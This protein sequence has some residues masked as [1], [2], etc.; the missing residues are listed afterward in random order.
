MIEEENIASISLHYYMQEEGVH[1]MDAF[2]HNKCERQLLN[3]INYLS[4]QYGI[5]VKVDIEAKEEGGIKDKI[6]VIAESA[7]FLLLAEKVL[8]MVFNL[9]RAYL[10]NTKTRFEIAEMIKNSSFTEEEVNAL[11]EQDE[12]LIKF[13]SSYFKNLS[14]DDTVTRV[15]T[16]L[17]KNGEVGDSITYTVT[18]DRF[19]DK[20]IA[21]EVQKNVTIITA[22]TLYVGS[23]V[24]INGLPDKW[25]G[26][27]NGENILFT[28]K[29]NEFIEQVFNREVKFDSG[30]SLTCDLEISE[31][32]KNGKIFKRTFTVLYVRSWT[33]GSHY[34]TETKRYIRELAENEHEE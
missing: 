4:K 23:P 7:L 33:D 14:K 6:I 15:E 28:I 22:T 25:R 24:L 1:E 18:K 34:Q 31:D 2:V 21:N 12:E 16:T 10:D 8:D 3:I 27:F 20:I 9:D 32:V 17:T 11:V 13:S 26:Q 19:Q 30:T 29:D 5:E